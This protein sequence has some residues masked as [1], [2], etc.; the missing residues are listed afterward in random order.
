MNDLSGFLFGA[1]VTLG[2]SAVVLIAQIIASEY[3]REA[4]RKRLW[5]Y[6]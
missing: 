4:R 1:A 6:R 3:R 5:P 2:I